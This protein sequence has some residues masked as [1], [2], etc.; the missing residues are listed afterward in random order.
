MH[1][2]VLRVSLHGASKFGRLHF[3]CFSLILS[4][5]RAIFCLID[6]IMTKDYYIIVLRHNYIGLHG[7]ISGGFG[8][9]P[10]QCNE[11]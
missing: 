2:K 1:G 5:K 9:L 4:L 8:P 3:H 7:L 6:R 11:I 10:Y